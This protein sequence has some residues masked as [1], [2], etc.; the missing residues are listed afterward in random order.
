M[1]L[2]KR[3]RMTARW[4][5]TSLSRIIR[6]SSTLALTVLAIS[7]FS[8]SS[9]SGASST[10]EVLTGVSC[11]QLT[12]VV[13]GSSNPSGGAAIIARS[14]TSGKK[15]NLQKTPSDVEELN[16]V[17]CISATSCK[18][19]GETATSTPVILASPVSGITWT[20]EVA[21]A[22]DG[23]LLAVSCASTTDCWAGGY[24]S[25]FVSG[26]I[27]ETTN[28]GGS[29]TP[30]AVPGGST[31]PAEVTG[32]S[33]ST[34]STPIHCFATGNWAN[35]GQAPYLMKSTTKVKS[36]SDDVLPKTGGV[37]GSLEGVHCFGASD[38][39][40]VGTD[41]SYYILVTKN[42]GASFTV[43]PAPTS[44]KGLSSI[45]CFSKKSCVAVGRS[46]NGSAAIIK[47]TTEGLT[48]TVETAPTGTGS[49]SSVSCGSTTH[50]V[51]VGQATAGGPVVLTTTD[52]GS[53]WT[54]VSPPS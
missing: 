8:L 34:S 14:S 22:A 28:G 45:S 9:A 36:W 13:V 40:F 16:G 6:A 2:Q 15:W 51:A 26:A 52:G 20:A 41:A 30:E 43:V 32:F 11:V 23:D 48:W 1:A 19:V 39:V 27:A 44:V 5:R 4:Q 35:Y 21:P 38:C 18:S 10:A 29:W 33:C 46:T 25:G 7:A 3:L 24:S 54:S 31:G 50:C 17:F 47:S 12:C 53:Q 37:P 49:L 42:A